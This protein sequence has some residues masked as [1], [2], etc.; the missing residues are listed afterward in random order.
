MSGLFGFLC[1]SRRLPHAL[2][3]V[4]LRSM[5]A[6]DEEPCDARTRAYRYVDTRTEPDWTGH[7]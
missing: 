6:Q 5:D 3:T 4:C 7:G 1:C 2:W